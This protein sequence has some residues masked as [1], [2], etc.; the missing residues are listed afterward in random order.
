MAARGAETRFRFARMAS[1]HGRHAVLHRRDPEAQRL[2]S[3]RSHGQ[4]AGPSRMATRRAVTHGQHAVFHR[5]DSEAQR[6][7]F[8]SLA[9]PS[10]MAITRS[11]TQPRER[12]RLGLGSRAWPARRTVTHGHM[13]GRH[14]WPA[15][16]FSPQRLGG[17]ETFFRFARMA[18][19]HGHRAS[20][21][22]HA[23]QKTRPAMCW[24]CGMPERPTIQ[25]VSAPQGLCGEKQMVMAMRAGRVLAMRAGRACWP[26]VLAVRPGRVCW[27]CVLATCWPCV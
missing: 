5:R 19:T 25:K 1:T 27:P 6:P 24:P 13:Q 11:F 3:V 15:R 22:S 2:F 20:A 18:I 9:W 14:A 21:P 16:G 10:R 26:C 8:G 12:P 23:G 7:F 4:H 17:A